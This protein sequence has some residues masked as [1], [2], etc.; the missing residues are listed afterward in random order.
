MSAASQ[1]SPKLDDQ[2]WFNYSETVI[3]GSQKRREDAATAIQKLVVWLWG[4]YTA[5][6]A[7][8]FALSGK[9]LMFWP[10]LMIAAASGAL[11][12]VYWGTV[13]VLV[14]VEIEFDPRSP[15]EIRNAYSEMIKTKSRRL[16]ITL[17]LSVVA[18]V[19]VSVALV[20]ASVS[21]PMDDGDTQLKADIYN[22]QGQS[23]V[24]ITARIADAKKVEITVSKLADDKKSTDIQRIIIPDKSGLLQTSLSWPG[25][26][27]QSCEVLL[28]WQNSRKE[29]LTLSKTVRPSEK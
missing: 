4:I 29:Q 11:I 19:M 2:Y 28:K 27:I 7:I 15:T 24:A 22:Q 26:T 14:P 17:L 9:E 23:T 5:S 20:L 1:A 6:T 10:T 21:K 3:T 8:G 25:E 13:W 12:L 18:A 16:N